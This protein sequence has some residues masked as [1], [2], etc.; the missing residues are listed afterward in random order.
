MGRTYSIQCPGRRRRRSRGIGPPGRT[1]GRSRQF[2]LG[3][4]WRW[5]WIFQYRGKES[6]E[7]D[8]KFNG[9]GLWGHRKHRNGHRRV[10]ERSGYC[11][12]GER[13]KRVMER[14]RNCHVRFLFFFSKTMIHGSTFCDFFFPEQWVYL[15]R[16]YTCSAMNIYLLS[17]HLISSILPSPSTPPRRQHRRLPYLDPN[18]LTIR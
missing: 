16:R 2:T 8:E 17:S 6:V 7:L 15:P 10:L 4:S 5:R 1:R 14:C 9:R 11:E 12:S 3:R 18:R 13:D